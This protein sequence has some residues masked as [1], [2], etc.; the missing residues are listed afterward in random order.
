[1]RLKSVLLM[2]K[3]WILEIVLVMLT[4]VALSAQELSFSYIT[5]ED[6]ISQSEV[7]C[8]LQDSGGYMWIGT[9]DGLNRYD[10]YTVKTFQMSEEDTNGL[11]HNTIFSLAEDKFGRIWIG[12]AEGLNLYN[13][14]TQLM[15]A[16]PNFFSGKQINIA[17]LLADE[18]N[19]WIGTSK[20]LFRMP[21]PARQIDE[22]AC[23]KFICQDDSC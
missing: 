17:A 20:G 19:L 7:Y 14:E 10:G 13:P 1:M 12:T 5:S 21:L 2:M 3:R 11:I 6:G 8:F 22:T 23:E 15:L 9:L 18:R 4:T 16:V